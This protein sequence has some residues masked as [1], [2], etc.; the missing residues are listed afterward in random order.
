MISSQ[1]SRGMIT[2]MFYKDPVIGF[3]LA[4]MFSMWWNLDPKS[5]APQNS[6]PFESDPFLS[7]VCLLEF[8]ILAYGTLQVWVLV[9]LM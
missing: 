1:N 9:V 3:T 2:R 8:C 5:K 4:L 6:Y 7:Q